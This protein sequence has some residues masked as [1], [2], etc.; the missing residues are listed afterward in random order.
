MKLFIG[1]GDR[2]KCFWC[3]GELICWRPDED[4]WKEHAKVYPTCQYVLNVKGAEFVKECERLTDI[5]ALYDIEIDLFEGCNTTE[6]RSN[7]APESQTCKVC[8]ENELSIV[9]LPC[10]HYCA[11]SECASALKVC[12]IC[13]AAFRG[14]IKV[15]SKR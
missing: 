12:P 13:R 14:F 15:L 10:C 8:L 6:S 7:D 11:C 1:V 4:P 9:I 3:S 5:Y 2:V